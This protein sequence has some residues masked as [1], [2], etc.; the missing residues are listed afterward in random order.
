M[1]AVAPAFKAANA[2]VGVATPGAAASPSFTARSMFIFTK[3]VG[4]ADASWPVIGIVDFGGNVTA[5]AGPFTYTVD[6]SIGLASW[7]AS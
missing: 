4:S 3:Q 7:T 6:P 2:S 1:S 5:T